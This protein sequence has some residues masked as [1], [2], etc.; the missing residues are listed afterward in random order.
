MNSQQFPGGVRQGEEG[1]SSP[2][3]SIREQTETFLEKTEQPFFVQQQQQK[4]VNSGIK[5]GSE[6][7]SLRF[8][9]FPFHGKP[10]KET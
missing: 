3:H 5:Q 1:R 10:G 7:E 9:G 2:L 6:R 8:T 4:P